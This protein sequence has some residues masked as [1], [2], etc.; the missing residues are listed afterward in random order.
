MSLPVKR[1]DRTPAERSWDPFAQ[2][3]ELYSQMGHV[4]R[5]SAGLLDGSLPIGWAPAIDLEE[6]D[7]EYIAEL[8]LPGVNVDDVGV[9]VAQSEVR[10]HGEIK[11]RERK[12]ILRRQTRKLGRFD[13]R[14]SLPGEVDTD[15]ITAELNDG[16][17]A[18][19]APKLEAAKPRRIRVDVK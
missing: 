9:D 11:Q 5:D 17:L 15:N 4:L 12:G 10:V 8:E 7:N 3:Q 13:Y 14:F 1:A 18:I 19:H 2:F 16:V 6:T